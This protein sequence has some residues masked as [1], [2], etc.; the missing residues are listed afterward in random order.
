MSDAIPDWLLERLACPSCGGDPLSADDGL[1]SCEQC[2]STYPV[3]EGI[4]IMLAAASGDGAA[5]KA[6][7]AQFFDRE[8]D[9]EY[10]LTRPSGTPAWH[11]RLLEEK[12]LRGVSG[13]QD[14]L[15]GAA[16]VSVCGGSGLDAEFLARHGARV[17]CADISLESVRRAA[18]RGR[19]R[20]LRIAGLVADAE[21]LPLRDRSFTLAYVHDGL[22]HLELPEQAL[23]EMA[24]VSE[25]AVSV[26]EPAQAA[27]TEAAVRVGLSEDEEEA[28]NE[29]RRLR[30][31]EIE[32]T[33]GKSG[34]EVIG[35]ERYAMLYRHEPGPVSRLL[36]RPALLEPGLELL[37]AANRRIGR[38]GNKL[39][40]RAVRTSG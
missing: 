30:I 8:A 10:E 21:R 33:L 12:F 5:A 2:A 13:L 39:S 35:A 19:R 17:A 14:L 22:H 9:P 37:A 15:P 31:E 6:R 7:Q 40:V 28:G 1:L 4:P 36:S 29:V 24:R 16:A 34:F 25:R 20:G 23:G 38:F 26:N 3:E 32:A 18:E 27:I 11:G